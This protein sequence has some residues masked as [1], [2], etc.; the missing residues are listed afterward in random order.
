MAK[1]GEAIEG[2]VEG[3]KNLPVN[4]EDEI[5]KQ[6]MA[7]KTQLGALP[8]NKISTRGKEFTLPD[9]RKAK[10]SSVSF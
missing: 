1:K 9:G 6:L 2:E 7:Q 3:T 4:M 5:R 8:S 10:S